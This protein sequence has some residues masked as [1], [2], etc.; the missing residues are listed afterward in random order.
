MLRD[1]QNGRSN[2]SFSVRSLSKI[3]SSGAS[4]L[5]SSVCKT[6]ASI[7]S[8][9][10]N[11]Q[12]HSAHDQVLWAGFDKLECEGDIRQIL[13][14]G[15]RSGFQVWDVEH[16]DDISQLVSRYDVSATFLQM[17][18]NPIESKGIID[19][20]ADHRPLL[21]VVGN[22]NVSANS[23]NYDGYDPP[24]NGYA[25]GFGQEPSNDSFLLTFVHFYSLRTHEYVHTLKFRSTI[26]S[27]RCSPRIIVVS[28]ASQIHCL[29]A[30]TLETEYS[31]L[32]HH[33]V[34]DRLGA[35]T[36]GYGP[37]AVGTRWLA[38]SGT[39]IA[40]S[41]DCHISHQDINPATVAYSDDSPVTNF[42]RE[43][44]KMLAAGLVTLGDIGYRTVSKYYLELMGVNNIPTV[45]GNSYLERDDDLHRD[46]AE[47]EQ[48][49][50]VIVRDIVSKSVIVQF[51]AH[52]SPISALS[53][54]PSG[55]LLATASIHGHNINVFRVIPTLHASS[56]ES[57]ANGVCIHLYKLRRGIT[58]AV[59]Q[60]I[61]FSDDSNWIMI[62]SSRGTSH[63][64][65][66]GSSGA[67]NI[68]F[69]RRDFANSSSG[70]SLA[71]KT[72]QSVSLSS[73]FCEQ[74][75]SL[76]GSPV[77]LSAVSR[78]KNGNPG[79]KNAVSCVAASATGKVNPTLGAI[80]SVFHHCKATRLHNNISSLRTKHYLLVYFSGSIIQYGLRPK[81]KEDFDTKLSAEPDADLVVDALQKWDIR[82][83]KNMR[84]RCDDSD[85]FGEHGDREYGKF[86]RKGMKRGTS[87]Y[88]SSV[89]TDFNP[90]LIAKEA[91][92][93]YISE[94]ELHV[95]EAPF[96]LWTKS[97]VQFQVLLDHHCNDKTKN[98]VGEIEVERI[99]CRSI[100]TRLT[101]PIPVLETLGSSTLQQS[102]EDDKENSPLSRQTSELLEDANVHADNL[103]SKLEFVNSTIG[104]S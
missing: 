51:M 63:L 55:T 66:T 93:S 8:S 77:T 64:F 42:A 57:Y 15:Y 20:F 47:V 87:V 82:H 9:I 65:A 40:N 23:N 96:P 5:A 73:K 48:G 79:L 4:N 3:V 26:F 10:A 53:F 25:G 34:S 81:S 12:D 84:D 74:N 14:L 86:S 90:M 7:V 97:Q 37:I 99:Q 61:S 1:H 80:A 76:C 54:D 49:G 31:I 59:I 43:S 35:G 11:S 36:V 56:G 44:S 62:S 58:N 95:H 83:K 16:S 2:G 60:D 91:H 6:G 29:N 52:R 24:F 88:P 98:S 39:P 45:N 75:P 17:Q 67:A 101:D 22:S 32:T 104:I 85:I 94:F 46:P 70:I 41:S 28:Q 72:K 21:I 78:I 89:G 92:H 13:L 69:T 18:K 19:K 27:V 30:L 102:R 38:H 33:V 50:M 100:K 71:T 68:R 103:K